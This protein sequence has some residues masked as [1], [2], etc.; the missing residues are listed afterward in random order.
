MS[1]LGILIL[2]AVVSHSPTLSYLLELTQSAD[3]PCRSRR[4]NEDI[5]PICIHAMNELLVAKCQRASEFCFL[6]EKIHGLT[7]IP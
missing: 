5:K 6:D 7:L 2:A 1:L 4:S 3:Y